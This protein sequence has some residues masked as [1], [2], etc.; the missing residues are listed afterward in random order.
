MLKVSKIL[1]ASGSVFYHGTRSNVEQPLPSKTG[2][3]ILWVC[4]DPAIALNYANTHFR[5]K[6][7]PVVW[8]IN[9]RVP[10]VSL[11]DLSN[12]VIRELKDNFSKTR[13]MSI[14]HEISD[15]QWIHSYADFGFLEGYEWSV[16]FL[17][18]K[19]VLAVRVKDTSSMGGGSE[20]YSIAILADRAISKSQ[21]WNGS[22]TAS[23]KVSHPSQ[24]EK[25]EFKSWFQGS[26][27]VDKAGNPLRVFHGTPHE[28]ENF[29]ISAGNNKRYT[30]ASENMIF[31]TSCPETASGY[32]VKRE[33]MFGDKDY[34]GSNVR[35]CYLKMVKPM[36]VNAKGV[37]WGYIPY[38]DPDRH[39]IMEFAI[40]ELAEI[41]RAKGCDGLVVTNVV[42]VRKGG[43]K[44]TTFAVFSTSQIMSAVG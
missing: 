23:Y 35:P 17:K 38:M 13:K 5:K 33:N 42:D 8:E 18:S 19:G 43:G 14:G 9:L 29:D 22:K 27:I 1:I 37:D 4:E 11:E 28:F 7:S 40:P 16:K 30:G 15:E 21:V 25:S 32:S 44:A 20:I 2:S 3:K 34:T 39:R 12:P 24:W 36:K 31:F 26:K 41:A 10:V 6:G